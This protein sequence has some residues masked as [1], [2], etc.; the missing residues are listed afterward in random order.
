MWILKG[1]W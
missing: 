1:R